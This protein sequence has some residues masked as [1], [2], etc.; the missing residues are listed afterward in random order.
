MPR[1]G[2]NI[3]LDTTP[4]PSRSILC[5]NLLAAR[6]HALRTTQALDAE[7][8]MTAM[9]IAVALTAGLIAG[10]AM[11]TVATGVGTAADTAIEFTYW[12]AGVS[13]GSL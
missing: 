4:A 9:T 12:S 10:I 7:T 13:V 3:A 5:R 11:T 2:E 6:R 1:T 8:G